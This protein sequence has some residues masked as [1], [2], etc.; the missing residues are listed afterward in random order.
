MNFTKTGCCRMWILFLICLTFLLNAA[1]TLAAD[2]KSVAKIPLGADGAQGSSTGLPD[3]FTGAM[4]YSIPIEVP[5][6]RKGMDPGLALNY[7]SNN[8]NG[9]VGVGWELGLGAIQRSSQNGINFNGGSYQFVK[10]GA[11][12]DLVDVSS[13]E[14]LAKVES[15]FMQVKQQ[16]AADGKIFWSVTDKLGTTYSYGATS[17]SR[18]DDPQDPQ[19]IFKWCLDRI[20]DSNGNYISIT[21]LKDQGQIYPSLISYAGNSLTGTS[22]S[23]FVKFYLQGRED[24]TDS[25]ATNF[26]VKTAYRLKTIDV[27]GANSGYKAYSLTYAISSSR[28]SIVTDLQVFGKDAVIT[29]GIVTSGT[30]LPKM[31]FTTLASNGGFSEKQ[32]YANPLHYSWSEFWRADVNGDGK[33][34]I[35]Y[36]NQSDTGID[37]RLSTL[38]ASAPATTW[39]S[40]PRPNS[41]SKFWLVDVNGDGRSDLVYM[42]STDTT[43]DV[44]L[45][46]GSGFASATPWSSNPGPNAWSK[47]WMVDVSGDGRPDLVYMN[48]T[49]TAMQVKLN[50]GSGFAQAATWSSNPLP[51]SWSEFW[52]ADVNGDGKSDLLYRNRSDTGIDVMLSTGSAFTPATNWCPNPMP[53]SWSKFWPVDVSG[54]GRPDLVYMN[55]NDTTLDVKLNTGSSFTPAFSWSLNPHPYSWGHFWFADMHGK[56][57]TDIVY[58]RAD[59]AAIN[60]S[61]NINGYDLVTKFSNGIGGSSTVA[62]QQSTNLNNTQL[63][64]NVQ[65]VSSVENNDGNGNLSKTNFTFSGGYYH[66]AERDF[67]G[68]NYAKVTGPAGP[69]NEQRITETWFHQGN[70]TAPDEN[71]P[72]ASVGYMKGKPYRELTTDA[73]G[74][75]FSEV[76]T[77]YTPDTDGL[78]PYHTPTGQIDSYTYDGSLDPRHAR[79]VYASYDSYGN[80]LEEHQYGD[81]DDATDDRTIATQYSHNVSSGILGLPSNRSVFAGIGIVDANKVSSTDFYYDGVDSGVSGCSQISTSQTPV[82][83]NMTR[84]V[85]W[86]KNGTNPEKR[87]AYDLVGNAVCSRDANGFISTVTYDASQTFPRISTN[88]L[89]HQTTTQYYGVDAVVTDKGLYGQVKQIIDPNQ[90]ATSYEY[91]ALGRNTLTTQPGLWV[92]TQYLNL[93]NPAT[94]HVRIDKVLGLWSENYFDGMGRTIKTRESGPDDKVIVT[95]TKY[96]KRGAVARSSF[97]YFEGTTNT[98]YINNSYDALGRITKSYNEAEISSST[99]HACYDRGV[100]V[101][102]DANNHRKRQTFN[103]YGRLAQV[104]EYTGSYPAPCSTDVLTPYATT[105]YQYDVMGNLTSVTDAQANKTEMVYDTLGRKTSML[106]PDMGNWSYIYDGNGNLRYQTDAKA[107]Q[108]EFQ[109]DSLNRNTFKIYPNQTNDSFVYDE[110]F[111]TNSKGRLTTMSDG[112]GT[113]KFYYDSVGR[114]TTVLK[115]L[116]GS[117]YNLTSTYDGLGRLLT[118]TYPDGENIVYTYNTGGDLKTAGSYVTYTDYNALRQKG[119]ATTGNGVTSTYQ[120]YPENNRLYSITTNS[121]ASGQLLNL[122]YTYYNTGSVKNIVDYS[123]S[124]G[125][126]QD[127][128]Y[129]ELDRLTNATGSYGILGYTYDKIGNMVNNNGVTLTHAHP[130]KP[131]AVTATTNGRSYSYDNNGNV[132]SDGIQTFGYN[133]NNMPETINNG[134]ISFVYDGSGARVKKITSGGTKL[135]LGKYYECA[136]GVCGKYIFAGED[137]I[138]LK[139]A[140]EVL[141]YHPDHLGSTSVVT[142]AA[143]N[144]VEDL[145]YK[146]FGE[147][148]LDVGSVKLNHKFTGQELDSETGLYNYRARLYDPLIGKFLSPDTIVTDPTNPQSLNRF[149]YVLNNPVR[150]TDPTGHSWKDFWRGVKN[151][152]E[153]GY[154]SGEYPPKNSNTTNYYI[155]GTGGGNSNFISQSEAEWNKMGSNSGGPPPPTRSST[156]STGASSSTKGGNTNPNTSA[157]VNAISTTAGSQFYKSSAMIQ[158]YGGQ[159][160]SRQQVTRQSNATD[161]D[162]QKMLQD[163]QK[164]SDVAAFGLAIAGLEPPAIGFAG[165]SLAARGAEMYMYPNHPY[166]D[167]VS[168][169]LKMTVSLPPP[170][171]GMFEMAIGEGIG[172]S[173]DLVKR[174]MDKK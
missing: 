141:Y 163:F 49:D 136:G 154:W 116:N 51:F 66:I 31:T 62:Y 129:D 111:S 169:S 124:G 83:G 78:A 123:A 119:T 122:A 77:S 131:H 142:D 144:K 24:S 170:Y 89:G 104:E 54:D 11:T 165:M 7:R 80:L 90:A 166:V 162:Y 157:G 46:T 18:Q 95:E 34:D 96:D 133:Y 118:L 79:T 61:Q 75:K 55:Y 72:N 143:G 126:G 20:E 140:A 12:F 26:R 65:T 25:Y 47:F 93:G 82:K 10:S 164:Y 70:D 37:V 171:G 138:A 108:I 32:W 105:N 21:Y 1:G 28:Q 16:T 146:P 120:Y 98:K 159:S 86:N 115:T 109:Y 69:N 132:S 139:T 148:T 8:G 128:I 97:P 17:A 19:R 160:L 103:V 87:L 150:Y 151:L 156:P 6:G 91:D 101:T 57:K 5:A 38:G 121:P 50:T 63:P 112:S 106:D 158:N 3:L 161:L 125:R 152:L 167:A 113:T 74:K 85:Y 56:G 2:S 40:N 27:S 107:Q 110:T 145:K 60:V 88:P 73:T 71:N 114:N 48:Y 117:I 23:N 13:G 76:K 172:I 64:F 147:S 29:N 84:V 134:A 67:R 100:H 36:R 35:V 9:W 153:T 44:R 42:N 15:D 130:S 4:S 102:I 59:Q 58:L 22:T 174:H 33:M 137:R 92:Q 127:F 173:S 14:Y 94:Q 99:T 45:S 30:A 41:W 52:R 81:L 168:E 53:N 155:S 149:S 135:Y 68:F 39:C 43:L